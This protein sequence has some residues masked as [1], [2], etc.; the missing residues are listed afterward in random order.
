MTENLASQI[1][2]QNFNYGLPGWY[3]GEETT[4][5]YRGHEF[6]P[7]FRNISHAAGQ[8]SLCST[9]TEARVPRARAPQQEKLLQ[10]EAHVP[11]QRVAPPPCN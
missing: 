5:Q 4:C 1:G 8:L 3:S 9:T 7:W 2:H 6:D 11:Q 10:S